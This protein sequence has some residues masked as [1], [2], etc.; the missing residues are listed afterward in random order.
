MTF[1]D[2][3]SK[4]LLF[5]ILFFK[6]DN[7]T[8]ANVLQLSFSMFIFHYQLFN[9]HIRTNKIKIAIKHY[10]QIRRAKLHLSIYILYGVVI[11]ATTLFSSQVFWHTCGFHGN[12]TKE[13]MSHV[14][15]NWRYKKV[16]NCNFT[17]FLIIPERSEGKCTSI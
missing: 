16:K 14:P 13:I 12:Q 11:F 3:S 7:Y 10:G 4:I 1:A 6:F 5:S 17:H 8:S 15:Q 9:Y 2:D